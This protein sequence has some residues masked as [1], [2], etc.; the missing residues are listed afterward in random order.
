MTNLTRIVAAIVDMKKATLYKED[1]TTIVILQG[2]TRLRPLLEQIT[3]LL[4][5]QRYADV[6]LSLSENS[7]KDFEEKTS[8]AVRFFRIA[9]SKLANILGAKKEIAESSVV[10]QFG[11]P[12]KDE[13]IKDVANVIQ[14]VAVS[15][16]A[17]NLAAVDEIMKHAVPVTSATFDESKIAT[18]RP[19]AEGGS[20]PNDAIKDGNDAHFNKHS[21]TIVAVTPK[22]NVVAGVE[23]IKSQVKAASGKNANA[24]GLTL[25]LE[26]IAAVSNER[27]HTV[28]DL[29][30]FMERGDL[31]IADDGCIIIYKRLNRR[32]DD[33]YVDYHSNNVLQKVGSYVHMDISLVDHNRRNECSNGLHVARRGYI[34]SFSGNVCVLAKVRPE[35]VIAVPDY[36]ANKMRVCGY[37]IIAE[38]TPEQ[39]SAVQNNRGIDNAPGGSELLAAAMS[40]DHIGITQRVKITGSKGTGLEITD[41]EPAGEPDPVVGNSVEETASAE[42]DAEEKAV[43]KAVDKA[44]PAPKKKTVKSKKAKKAKRKVAVKKAVATA[45]IKKANSIEAA[46]ALRSDEAVDPKA[47][48]RLK[49]GIT[50]TLTDEVKGP[51]TQTEFV[52]SLWDS[53]LSGQDGKAQELLDFEKKAKK[54]WTVWGLPE[55]AGDT[56][57]ALLA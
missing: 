16:A 22:G 11:T 7:Y 31:P 9:K 52:K 56:L 48:Q 51:M 42:P 23:R 17:K 54:G 39:F 10:G 20:T 12:P 1:G 6:D 32:G 34:K 29:L 35:D 21:E 30:R 33:T 15:V 47:L 50:T 2:D 44:N 43:P 36:D 26:R 53:A 41:I 27:K 55:T 5:S 19:T 13:A 40:G 46:G 14:G 8:G 49:E 4:A 28:D 24:K 18:Q 38:L 45:T 3:P 57:K 25:F 37:H